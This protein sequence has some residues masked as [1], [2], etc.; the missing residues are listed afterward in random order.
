[1]PYFKPFYDTAGSCIS[2][3]VCCPE[4]GTMAV[5]DP[6]KDYR[7]YVALAESEG[8]RITHVI[9]SHIHADHVSGARDLVRNLGGE[10]ELCMAAGADVDFGFTPLEEG[11]K[12]EVGGATLA[13]IR[14]PGH[15]QES[16]SLLYTDR[17]RGDEPWV[18]F[19]GDAL[20]V[21]DVGRLDLIGHGTHEQAYASLRRLLRLPDYVEVCP[22]HYAGSD[23]ASNRNL[24]FK[25]NSTVGFERRF[26]KML[27]WDSFEQFEKLMRTDPPAIPPMWRVIK[28]T[29]QG[30][31][32]DAGK[33]PA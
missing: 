9:D 31:G 29:N 18:V 33:A 5:I 30:R 20:F 13:P 24:S 25:T 26:N 19:T 12:V 6:S 14:T 11:M 10:A 7:Q 16:I 21:G 8:A 32:Q 2:Y 15:T 3:V 23:C 17:K 28:L 1:M 4:T 22:A 27:A